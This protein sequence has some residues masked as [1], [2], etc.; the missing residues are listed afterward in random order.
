MAEK[1]IVEPSDEGGRTQLVANALDNVNLSGAGQQLFTGIAGKRLS[2][3]EITVSPSGQNVVRLEDD[4][5]NN[6]LPRLNFDTAGGAA[7]RRYLKGQLVAG[8]GKG[9]KVI[10]SA[11]AGVSIIATAYVTD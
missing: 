3:R 5:T 6:V 8:V 10:A 4:D 1:F 11:S 2:L 7:P 9:I